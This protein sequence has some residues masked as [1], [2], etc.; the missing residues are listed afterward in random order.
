MG[1]PGMV[2]GGVNPPLEKGIGGFCRTQD[3]PRGSTRQR[4]ET[5]ADWS[6]KLKLEFLAKQIK[7]KGTHREHMIRPDLEQAV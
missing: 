1:F 6:V 4:P 7:N 5:S 3:T 2:R